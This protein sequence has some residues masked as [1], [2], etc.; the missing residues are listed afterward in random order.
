[1]KTNS[2]SWWPDVLSIGKTQNVSEIIV[3]NLHQQN[4]FFFFFFFFFFCWRHA[5]IF[6][7]PL[8]VDEVRLFCDIF[9]FKTASYQ[10]S[11]GTKFFLLLQF[12]LAETVI[13]VKH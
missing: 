11:G 10:L 7:G 12:S 3:Y 1:M 4:P 5:K 2:D 13:Y 9:V 8:Q 6:N